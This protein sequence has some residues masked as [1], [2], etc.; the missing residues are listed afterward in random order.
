MKIIVFDFDKTLTYKDTLLD[1]FTF[2]TTKNITFP[3]RLLLY[4]LLMLFAKI[5]FISND[6]MK[7]GGIF[8]FI[9]GMKSSTLEEK[10]KAYSN[11]ITFN[12]LYKNY[13]F[14]VDDVSIYIVSASF[15]IYIKY[16]FPENANI[17]GSTFS[18][19]KDSISGLDFNCYALKKND[20]L[21]SCGI[22]FIDEFYTDSYSDL[23]LA[24]ISGK[25]NVINGDNM[26]T[27]YNINEFKKYFKK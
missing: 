11:T 15:S 22:H 10:A 2:S 26:F 5:N 13:N 8:L 23:S 19:A 21:S 25:I 27:F 4:Y 17:I 18:I 12:T 16:I 7:K 24:E 3:F 1:F 14:K 9:K 20:A 6:L